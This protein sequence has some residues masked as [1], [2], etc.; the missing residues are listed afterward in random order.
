MSANCR[1]RT[2]ALSFALLIL[3]GPVAAQVQTG[4]IFGKVTDATRAVVPGVTV[5]IESPALIQPQSAVTTATG[6]YRFPSIPIGHYTVR[7]VL[8]GFKTLVRDGIVITTGFNAEIDVQ[9]EVSGVAEVLVV[10]GRSP[11]VDTKSTTLATN[12]TR[13]ALEMIPSAR[14]PWVILQQ[15]PGIVM[16]Q[17]NV[18]GNKSG[19]QSQF[20]ARGS[21]TNQT[22]SLE[23]ATITDR[24]AA[25]SPSYYDFDSFAEIQ[26]Q[27]GGADAS[28]QGGGVS[29]NMI[30]R[31]GSNQFRGSA[32]VHDANE[33]FES[34]NVSSDLRAQGAT[35]GNPI[36]NILEYGAEVGGPIS[37]DKAWFW[38]AAARNDIT[39]GVLNFFKDTGDCA[40]LTAL[41]ANTFPTNVVRGC[42]NDD[43][44]TLSNV[45]GKLN[46]Q[47]NNHHKSTFFYGRSSKV[48][49]AATAGPYNPPPTTY[50]Q[51]TTG[52]GT[53][54]GQ[55]QWMVSGHL[56][57]EG[58]YTYLD[59]GFV[60]DYHD[61][62]LKNVQPTYDLGTQMWGRSGQRSA[63]LRPTTDV[64]ADGTYFLSGFGGGDHALKF[65]LQYLR[66]PSENDA[67]FG[68]GAVA[69]FNYGAPYSVMLVQ[70][71]VL[72]MN[73]WQWSAY[74]QDS[75]KVK[76]ATIN[77][78]VR[79]DR[80]ADEALPARIPAHPFAPALLPA[81]DFHGATSGVVF[82]TVSPRL[83]VTYDLLGDNHTVLKAAF[84]RYYGIGNST[85]QYFALSQGATLGFYWNDTNQD[86]F[87]QPNEIQFAR[88]FAVN[89]PTYYN[90]S[91]PSV[92]T[93]R[94]TVSPSL[95]SDRTDEWLVRIDREV[96]ENLGVSASYIHRRYSNFSDTFR[97]GVTSDQY[98]AVTWT[99]P[100]ATCPAD[101]NCPAVTYYQ[102]ATPLPLDSVV[103]NT[104]QYRRYNGIEL[105]ATKRYAGKWMLAFAMTWNDTRQYWPSAA[106]VMD[107]TNVASQDG[108]QYGTVN[109]RWVGKLSGA[110]LMPFGFM[111]SAFFNFRQGFP[112][113]PVVQSPQRTG[114]GG[115]VNV[116]VEPVASERYPAL[117]QLDVRV[118]RAVQV[119]KLRV[120]VAACVFNVLNDATVLG[121]NARQN[122]PTANYV[123]SILAPRVARFDLQVR[124]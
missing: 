34:D 33:R 76:R 41:N 8:D 66:T 47:W 11:V 27:T 12:V 44:A 108:R 67:E 87:V 94:T 51:R 65:G 74:L 82:N 90:P 13:Q 89:P 120:T 102:R 85:S 16:N 100:A 60:F 68:G 118:D 105:T 86:G 99:P 117:H 2:A 98:T 9:L 75:Y 116:F 57:L 71:G 30:T 69:V 29:V 19:Q 111:G 28:I 3:A 70:P 112:F 114:Q 24:A 110:Y 26:I 21:D 52:A 6:A 81:V 7:F 20:F 97:I 109:A 23:G 42:L 78:G 79:W 63:D 84:A 49:N 61:D 62:S 93:Q 43:T 40:A 92:R 56:M 59:N 17:E 22:W 5:T 91:N 64:R 101:A 96:V 80:Q 73:Q 121:R 4:E 15:T 104:S 38:A 37:R 72:R 95:G 46:Y 32:R 107:P 54:Q 53:F 113:N 25:A 83:G 18:G 35:S 1:I 119:G 106:D 39:V 122:S 45:N 58:K 31:S 123:T 50:R 36:T 88:G 14:D 124:F 48:R 77:A 103:R 115:R 55:H 10:S